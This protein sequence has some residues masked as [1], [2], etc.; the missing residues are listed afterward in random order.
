MPPEVRAVASRPAAAGAGEHKGWV[1]SMKA[2]GLGIGIGGAVLAGIVAFQDISVPWAPAKLVSDNSTDIYLADKR[3]L[4]RELMTNRIA[5]GVFV[6]DGEKVPDIY[7]EQ[8]Q[9]FLEDIE[10]RDRQL[11]ELEGK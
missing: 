7:L 8:E 5:Q 3:W 1:M 11:R 2:I 4:N 9:G 10:K 6:M